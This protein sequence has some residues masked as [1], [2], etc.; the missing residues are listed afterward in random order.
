MRTMT[1]GICAGCQEEFMYEAKRKGRRYCSRACWSRAVNTPQ[2]MAVVRAAH[3]NPDWRKASHARLCKLCGGEYMP[4]SNRQSVC[5]LCA[6]DKSARARARR[7]GLSAQQV[8]ELFSRHG[9]LCWICKK[10]P[11][12]TIDH[13]HATGKVR[14][15]LCRGCNMA[16]H[17]VERPG[18]WSTA[19]AY[20]QGGDRDYADKEEGAPQVPGTDA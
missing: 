11:A 16:L 3:T 10:N 5:G 13:C 14:G 2:R 19:R 15:A 1:T 7:Y 17:F 18:W 9:G 8:E 6:P 4:T 12:Q 20:L